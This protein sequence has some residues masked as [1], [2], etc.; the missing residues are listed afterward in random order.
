MPLAAYSTVSPS[1][2]DGIGFM[3]GTTAFLA[4]ALGAGALNLGAA[5]SSAARS[6]ARACLRS[7]ASCAL[8]ALSSLAPCAVSG[9]RSGGTDLALGALAPVLVVLLVL[10]LLLD[11]LFAVRDLLLALVRRGGLG[12]L[13]GAHGS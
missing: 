13:T 8:A 10:D 4:A 2:N 11:G 9:A 1:S 5:A 6:L 12:I 7:R 3:T